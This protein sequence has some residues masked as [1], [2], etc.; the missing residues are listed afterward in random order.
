MDESNSSINSSIVSIQGVS[1]KQNAAV[2][3]DF[4]PSQNHI[5]VPDREKISLSI[6]KNEWLTDDAIEHYFE[7]LSSKI[8][9]DGNI[10]IIKFDISQ[11]IKCL[12]DIDYLLQ[13]SN[14]TEKSYLLIPVNDSPAV[15]KYQGALAL[16]GACYCI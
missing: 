16:T 9:K 12:D 4:S 11:A 14:L 8:I 2:E 1:I 5:Q 10:C 6:I 13:G 15:D 7:L 3:G